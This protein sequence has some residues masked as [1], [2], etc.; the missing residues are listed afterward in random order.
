MIQPNSGFAMKTSR[1][2]PPPGLGPVLSGQWAQAEV[3]AGASGEADAAGAEEREGGARDVLAQ[4]LRLHLEFLA[5]R[6]E[7]GEALYVGPPDD[8]PGGHDAG[9]RDLLEPILTAVEGAVERGKGEGLF[10]AGLDP[11]MAALHYLGAIQ[12]SFVFWKMRGCSG[13]LTEIGRGFFEQ[14]LVSLEGGEKPR[15][16]RAGTIF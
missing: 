15:A 13:S 10:P 16:G 3:E 12:M 9:L 7:V 8:A 6:P 14:W 4:F 2:S 5:S 1:S 11:A